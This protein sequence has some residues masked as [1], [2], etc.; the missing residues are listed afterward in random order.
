MIFSVLFNSFLHETGQG[1]KHVN[2]RIDLFVV[3]LTIDE[4][5]SFCDVAGQIG[6]RVSD[7][8]VLNRGRGT[9]IDKMGI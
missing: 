9:G 3:E 1:G 8:V 7:V 5:L 6:D 2:G 4:D